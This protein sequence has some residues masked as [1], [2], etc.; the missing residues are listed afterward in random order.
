[1][2]QPLAIL[3]LATVLNLI[4]IYAI[5][6]SH[7]LARFWSLNTLVIALSYVIVNLLV[8]MAYGLADPR[9]RRS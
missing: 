3:T 7:N 8:D 5:Q 9:I 1:M 2:L 6:T 4:T